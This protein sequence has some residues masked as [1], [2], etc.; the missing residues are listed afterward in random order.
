MT[1]PTM[2]LAEIERALAEQ[3]RSL[4]AACRGLAEKGGP[5]AVRLAG[6]VVERL[7]LV[8]TASSDHRVEP[9]LSRGIRC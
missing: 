3:D 5:S 8:C 1:K 2:T 9:R 7:E 4:E 6:D